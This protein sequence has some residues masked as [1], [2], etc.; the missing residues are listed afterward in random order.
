MSRRSVTVHLHQYEETVTGT[1]NEW[2][3]V[4]FCLLRLPMAGCCS[5]TWP[6]WNHWGILAL[7]QMP[8]HQYKTGGLAQGQ[9]KTISLTV[10]FVLCYNDS[11]IP[12]NIKELFLELIMNRALI[13]LLVA[14]IV[15]ILLILSVVY[16]WFQ[17][18]ELVCT[19][20]WDCGSSDYYALLKSK[21]YLPLVPVE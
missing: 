13:V 3:V 11:M 8:Q 14:N 5:R 10:W 2:R 6:Q 7:S 16:D 15:M 18:L 21:V 4:G 19:W 12:N 17:H 1:Y 9:Q 20:C